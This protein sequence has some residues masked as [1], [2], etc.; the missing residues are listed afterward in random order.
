MGHFFLFSETLQTLQGAQGDQYQSKG[1][2]K[3]GCKILWIGPQ[4]I[5]GKQGV[6][7]VKSGGKKVSIFLCLQIVPNSAGGIGASLSVKREH[8]KGV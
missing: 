3:R 8:K 2:I 1:T 5:G 7:S 6:F 4:N